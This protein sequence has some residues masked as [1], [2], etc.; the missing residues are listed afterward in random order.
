MKDLSNIKMLAFD[1][2]GVMTDA[3]MIY[4]PDGQTKVFNA[5]DGLGIRLARVAGM[6]IVIIT[7]N[8]TPVVAQRAA[9]L[10][11]N[12]IFQNARYKAAGLKAASEKC[13]VKLEEIAYMGDDLNDLPAFELA[14]VSFAPANAVHDVK[15][16]ADYITERSG[17]HGAVR[18]MIEQI[19][20]AQGKWEDA[21]KAFL[22]VLKE[23]QVEG[24]TAGVVA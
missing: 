21:V 24:G 3:S 17:G 2:D 9:D 5:Q 4:G 12:A 18:E 8:I 19:L 15:N 11:V 22:E 6:N 16:A 10:K 1:V 7:G 20:K 13:G 23:E 14:G